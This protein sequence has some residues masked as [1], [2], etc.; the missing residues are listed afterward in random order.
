MK[1]GKPSVRGWRR[2]VLS[3]HFAGKGLVLLIRSQPNFRFHLLAAAGVI[4]AG[5]YFRVEAWEWV[6]LLLSISSVL[7]A[8]AL[9]SALEFLTDLVSPEYNPLAGKAKDAAAGAVLI[10]ALLAVGVG[11]VVFLPYLWSF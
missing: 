8:E 4:G 2:R 10:A 6:A 1:Q 9:N 11:L 7:V 5:L 3:F